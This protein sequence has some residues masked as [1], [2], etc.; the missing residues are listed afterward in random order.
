MNFEAIIFDLDGTLIDSIPDIADAANQIM[1]KHH[2][3]VHNAEQ[4]VEWIGN[5]AYRLLKR[6]VPENISEEYIRELLE[7]YLEVYRNNC[8]NKTRLYPG[9][10][11]L[12]DFLNEQNVPISI[13]TNKPHIITHKVYEKYLS[14]WNFNVILGQMEGYPK[15]PDPACALEIAEKLNCAP[16][17]VLFIGDSDTDIKTGTA[18]GMIPIGVIWG[19]GTEESLKEAGA[20]FLIHDTGA[21]LKFIKKNIT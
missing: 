2:F 21:L 11:H 19:Y 5:G 6:A 10:D 8:T 18:A 13:L 7:E 17:K 9:T 16:R 15:K 20:K 1:M 3:P 4:Y 14:K 12:F